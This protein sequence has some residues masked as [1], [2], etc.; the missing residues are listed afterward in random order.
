MEVG[1]VMIAQRI[2]SFVILPFLVFGLLV[3]AFAHHFYVQGKGYLRNIGGKL[4]RK[5]G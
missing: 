5:I 3:V 2:K 1:E 4:G